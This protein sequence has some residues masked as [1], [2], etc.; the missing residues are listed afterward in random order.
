MERASSRD[1]VALL[2]WDEFFEHAAASCGQ[3]G[4]WLNGKLKRRRGDSCWIG[5]NCTAMNG[6]GITGATGMRIM[7]TN[8]VHGRSCTTLK[9]CLHARLFSGHKYGSHLRG[10]GKFVELLRGSPYAI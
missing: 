10:F 9:P 6:I 2:E 5:E 4:P 8:P 1:I 7:G 3:S